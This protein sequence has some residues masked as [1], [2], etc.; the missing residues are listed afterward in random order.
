MRK[1]LRNI[2]LNYLGSF[3][4]ISNGVHILNGHY[5]SSQSKSPDIFLDLLIKLNQ[6]ADF[7][8]IQDAINLIE[9]KEVKKEKLIAFTFDDGF[10]ECYTKIAPAL[11]QFNTNAAYFIN[12]GFI[13]GDDAYQNNFRKNIV[14]VNKT[15]MT[16]NMIRKLHQEGSIIGNHT[17]DHARLIDKNKTEL[18]QQITNSK[19]IIEKEIASK[20]EHFAWPYGSLLD[21]NNE[22]LSIAINNHKYIFSSSNYQKYYSLNN[23]VI[24]RRHMEGNWPINHLKYF[25]SRKNY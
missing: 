23:Q 13:N 8:N 5:I 22:A 1:T 4:S 25:L 10:E 7:I 11:R 6:H 19:I 16:W 20:C 17:M 15:P 24:N 2:L 12:P 21:I 14:H 18:I 3:K 9:L